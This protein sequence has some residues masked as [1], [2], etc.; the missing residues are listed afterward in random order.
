[1]SAPDPVPARDVPARDVVI[2]ALL[3]L[4]RLMDASEQGEPPEP[5]SLEALLVHLAEHGLRPL[6]EQ[7][8]LANLPAWL[9]RGTERGLG[10]LV[11]VLT[12]ESGED[13][14]WGFLVGAVQEVPGLGGDLLTL[15]GDARCVGAGDPVA[16]SGAGILD[17][18]A[19]SEGRAW[20]AGLRAGTEDGE[21]GSAGPDHDAAARELLRGARRWQSVSRAT[22]RAAGQAVEAVRALLADLDVRRAVRA[23]P[24]QA[25]LGLLPPQSLD[26]AAVAL[27]AALR[28]LARTLDLPDLRYPDR[29][30]LAAGASAQGQLGRRSYQPMDAAEARVRAEATGG[31]LVHPGD[32][33]W[34]LTPSA[35]G[36]SVRVVADP[37]LGLAGA[38]QAYWGPAWDDWQRAQHRTALGDLRWS[39]R[40]WRE[41]PANQPLADIETGQVEH[42]RRMFQGDSRRVAVLGGPSGSGKS[43]I[44]RCFLRRMADE[45]RPVVLLAPDSGEFPSQGVLRQV[46]RHALAAAAP[47]SDGP[48]RP[49]VVLDGIRPLGETD[50]DQILPSV[51]DELDVSLLAVLQYDVT[52]HHDWQ[53]ESLTVLRSVVRPVALA[54]FAAR[55]QA[56]HPDAVSGSERFISAM[57]RRYPHDLHR[58][59]HGLVM[60]RRKG[61]DTVE[62]LE[63]EL[64]ARFTEELGARTQRQVALV[65]ALSLL[66]G[67]HVVPEAELELAAE[68]DGLGATRGRLPGSYRFDSRADCQQLLAAFAR[69]EY[70]DQAK[71]PEPGRLL[72]AL[73]APVLA[74]LLGSGPEEPSESVAERPLALL[75]GARLHDDAVCRQLTDELWQEH[76]EA[77]RGWERMASPLELAVLL[78]AVDSSLGDEMFTELLRTMLDGL[79]EARPGT[80]RELLPAVRAVHRY[81]HR[82]G[83]EELDRLLAWCEERFAGILDRRPAAGDQL[84]SL[85]ELFSRFH[86]AELDRFVA[87]RGAEILVGLDPKRALDYRTVSRVDEI[88]RRARRMSGEQ[89]ADAWVENTPEVQKLLAHTPNPLD[90]AALFMAA[91]VLR[92]RFDHEYHDW[93]AVLQRYGDRLRRALRDARA[94]EL[95]Y[96]LDEARRFNLVFVT[97]MLNSLNA[98]NS[99]NAFATAA[100]GALTRGALPAEAALLLRTVSEI[101]SA[102]ARKTI[103]TGDDP[104]ARALAVRLAE[105]VKES[106]DAKGAGLLLSAAARVDDLFLTGTKG[107]A[108]HLAEALGQEWVTRQIDGDPRISVQYHLIK[109]VWEVDASYR[110]QSLDLFV[111]VTARALNYSMRPWGPQ[112]ALLIGQDDEFGSVFIEKLGREVKEERLLS[113]MLTAVSL[114]ARR[115]FHRLGPA[116][117]PALPVAYLQRHTQREF[118]ERAR[119]SSAS[120]AALCARETIRTL[121]AGGLTAADAGRYVLLE[122]DRESVEEAGRRWAGRLRRGSS[123][124]EVT[125]VLNVLRQLDSAAATA[126]LASLDIR[127]PSARAGAG[128]VLQDQLRRAMY[129]DPV[130]AVGLLTA[131]EGLA[132]GR[133]EELMRQAQRDG[134]KLWN[135]FTVELGHIQHPTQQ[136]TVLRQLVTL[137]LRPDQPH[138][139]WMD[140]LRPRLDAM[141]REVT[142]PAPLRDLVRLALIW[143]TEW[144]SE[145]A[146]LIDAPKVARRLAHGR[147]DDLSQLAGLLS[148]L[149]TAGAD[150]GVELLLDV[151]EELP[152]DSVVR[153]LELR[154]ADALVEFARRCRP[155]LAARLAPALAES[156]GRR[157]RRAVVFDEAEHWEEIG[158]AAMTL[159]LMDR[160]DLIPPQLPGRLPNQAHPYAAVWGVRW[161][162]QQDW[163]RRTVESGMAVVLGAAR[164][165][166]GAAF[167]ALACASQA[168]RTGELLAADGTWPSVAASGARALTVLQG[169]AG[170]DRVLRSALVAQREAVLERIDRPTA[171][172]AGHRDLARAWFDA[173]PLDS[174]GA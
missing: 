121:V 118:A 27:P 99:T 123:S 108:W 7:P 91:L 82:I 147:V 174:L 23:A 1:M 83:D 122:S 4:D 48:G 160:V 33:G 15:L 120:S 126:V 79:P 42:L 85:L 74:E 36:P 125:E 95:R 145:L 137:G 40:E 140:N 104:H 46:V 2:G 6:I 114:E 115:Q 50:A 110:A 41:S 87:A 158:W 78:L 148:T 73:V 111:E 150:A 55:A 65:A 134:N 128:T 56:A 116:I 152:P 75:R 66:G 168:G 141:A 106:D 24:A 146:A 130:E 44:T 167:V 117:Y 21:S 149:R 96:A 131:V 164:P 52:T 22:G 86:D 163:T 151:L 3:A 129:R 69:T 28:T 14:P 20:V 10:R 173:E 19:L 76:R 5:K 107:C 109:G 159:R 136:Y 71:R 26:D 77:L 17:V 34:Y 25:A 57:C 35:G 89:S 98:P 172:T 70:P 162:P 94:W 51:A 124:S 54:D 142:G 154:F 53:T 81:R 166:P 157:V 92:L 43:C 72:V 105:L 133:G 165:S 62:E 127:R 12:E 59:S 32:G 97:K 39:L 47:P 37:A 80:A 171:R 45:G 38:A 155:A 170:E 67:E 90:G 161:L 68:L 144:A 93:D 135:T 8:A 169:M 101:H 156:I 113:G 60:A 30:V 143:R 61:I 11:G 112:V 16:R 63:E 29:P 119:A 84:F 153:S 139:A 58:F 100:R 18:V 49:V 103:F 13:D 64:R 88:V 132:P 9:V 102:T 138:S 31:A